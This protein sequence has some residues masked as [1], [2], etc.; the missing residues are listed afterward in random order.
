MMRTLILAICILASSAV[1]SESTKNDSALSQVRAVVTKGGGTITGTVAARGVRD[2][3]DVIVYLEHVEGEFEPPEEK[4]VID[5]QNLIFIPHVLPVLKGTTA[6][7][8][9]SDKVKHNVFSPSKT[10]K[11][12]L[13]TY[14]SGVTREVTFDK[15]GK[16][17]LL[18]NVHAEMSAYVY[19]LQNPF[20]ALT[21]PE[22]TFT[23]GNIPPGSYTIKTWH[24]K[25]K[26]KKQ[27]VTVVQ[28]DT[29]TVEFKLSR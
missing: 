12:N 24:E 27:K 17:S 26:V 14:A 4:P 8:T 15:P 18:C 13:G 11:F 22:G 28:G 3:R 6:Q 29:V 21:G 16:V 23:I 5:Q 1:S 10:K 19:V 25:L 20:F 7:F 9:N 2:A